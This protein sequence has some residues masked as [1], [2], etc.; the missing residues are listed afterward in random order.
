M[1]DV[2]AASGVISKEDFPES[3]RSSM[4]IRNG[5][6]VYNIALGYSS[7]DRE[8]RRKGSVE[9]HTLTMRTEDVSNQRGNL[10]LDS[11]GRQFGEQDCIKSSRYVQRD[12]P[13][14]MTDIEGLHPLFGRV[15]VACPRWR[16]QV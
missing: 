15:E 9:S 5:M 6:G 1:R 3:V 2:T 14:L 4:N 10:A 8:R 13:Y 11:I 12:G 7:L 16:D